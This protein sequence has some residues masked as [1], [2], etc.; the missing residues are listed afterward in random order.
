MLWCTSSPNI[1]IQRCIIL[2]ASYDE[3]DRRTTTQNMGTWYDGTATSEPLGWTRVVKRSC[4][5]VELHVTRVDPRSVDPSK[6]QY[7][8]CVFMR[9]EP[10]NS[11]WVVQVVLPSLNQKNLELVVE[12][13]KPASD[14][15]TTRT[16]TTAHND[17]NF[18]RDGHLDDV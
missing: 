8:S 2:S 6:I 10:M 15:T 16:T 12:V 3:V 18:V 9:V 14:D 13:G 1:S 4:L 17:I 11:P 7:A 5:G